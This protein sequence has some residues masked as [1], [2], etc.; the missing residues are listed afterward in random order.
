[1]AAILLMGNADF[2]EEGEAAKLSDE[3]PIKQAVT[4]FSVSYAYRIYHDI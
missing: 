2:T 4:P 1:M 3:G